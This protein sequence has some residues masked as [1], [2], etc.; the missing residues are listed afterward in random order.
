LNFDLRGCYASVAKF[1]FLYRK[2]EASIARAERTAATILASGSVLNSHAVSDVATPAT[3]L[4]DAWDA[5]LFN[6]F[7]DVLPGSSIERA[8]DDQ[9]AQVG[10]AIP[11]AQ[12]AE[13]AA[14]NALARRVDTRVA[15][16]EGDHPSP[17][18]LL[19]WNPHPQPYHGHVEME[20]CLD[21][22]PIWAY[23]GRPDALPVVL[24]DPAGEPVAFQSIA[25]E[26]LFAPAV[27]W[28]K[29]ALLPVELPPLGWAVYTLGW[30]EGVAAPPAP[31]ELGAF[32]VEPN[33]ISNGALDLWAEVGTGAIH[34][35]RGG[36]LVFG[37]AGM[38]LVTVADPWGSWGGMGEELESLSLSKV[39][40]RWRVEKTAIL[41]NGPERATLWVRLVGG[42][43]WAEL[44][45]HVYRGREDIEVA[46]RILWN[47]RSARLKMVFPVEA[48][49]AEFEVPGGVVTRYSPTGEVPGGRWVRAGSFGFASDA[50]YNFEL[51]GDG[52]LRATICRASR[53]A[54]ER[55][56][57]PEAA[58]WNPAV[59]AGEL[60]FRF[61]LAPADQIARRAREL[62]MP[63]VAIPVPA[64][65]GDLPRNGSLAALSPDSVHLLALKPAEDG[66]GIVLRAQ[67]TGETSVDAV[68]DWQG[69][70]LALGTVAAHQIATWR[71]MRD[72]ADT[73][74]AERTDIQERRTV[75]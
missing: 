24:R 63:P 36:E 29:R 44:T 75:G 22:R 49:S 7:H 74:R 64:S 62:E 35:L 54:A 18:A 4:G 42:S 27:P 3:A 65:P 43:S 60:R 13:L 46:A 1:K 51:S 66:D 72:D 12:Q 57:G 55:A 73:W 9:M 53:Y 15:Q 23:E 45:F 5:L 38:S 10:G 37:E 14:L 69:R 61:L 56:E 6:S 59:D 25:T 50:L 39:R 34:L 47:E 2:A 68:L 52:A 30:E 32:G 58:P 31:V 8:Y 67:N 16:P 19:V 26:H 33:A 41:E 28:R 40:H 11:Q 48:G 20:A 70:S 17:V 71:L 21:Y